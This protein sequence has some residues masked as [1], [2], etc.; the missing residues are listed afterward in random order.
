[1]AGGYDD[2]DGSIWMDG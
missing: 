1:M 2:R